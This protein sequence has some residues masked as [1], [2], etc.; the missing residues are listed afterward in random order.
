[1]F[2]TCFDLFSSHHQAGQYKNQLKEDKIK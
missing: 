2:A 1:M